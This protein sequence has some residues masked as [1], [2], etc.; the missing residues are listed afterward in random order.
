[1][2]DHT[3]FLDVGDL[4]SKSSMTALAAGV[5]TNVGKETEAAGTVN[6]K[7][8]RAKKTV[9]P[10]AAATG[11]AEVAKLLAKTVTH[12]LNCRCLTSCCYIAVTN[13]H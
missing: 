11:D 6:G 5:N 3:K 10:D 2:L 9:N 7:K 1:V 4:G 13:P 12:F 8:A